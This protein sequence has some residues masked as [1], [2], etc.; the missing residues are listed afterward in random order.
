M[1]AAGRTPLPPVNL[2][3]SL[4]C[5]RNQKK[6]NLQKRR[7]RTKLALPKQPWLLQPADVSCYIELCFGGGGEDGVSTRKQGQM[8]SSGSASTA[9]PWPQG[10]IISGG[11]TCARAVA[12]GRCLVRHKESKRE[13]RERGLS[14]H[15]SQKQHT[16][17]TK[18]WCAW[19]KPRRSSQPRKKKGEEGRRESEGA[20]IAGRC[21]LYTR[22]PQPKQPSSLHPPH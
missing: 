17:A 7:E 20:R 19:L 21:A 22:H 18:L 10:S 2:V 9:S 12:V 11:L 15:H 13:Q 5:K 3:V 8:C 4:L 14:S 16:V 1:T 6:R